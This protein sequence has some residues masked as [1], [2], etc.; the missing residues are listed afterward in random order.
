MLAEYVEVGED[1]SIKLDINSALQLAYIHSPSHQNQLETLYLS[2]LDVTAERFRLNTQYV[3]GLGAKYEQSSNS[4]RLTVGSSSPATPLDQVRRLFANA[5]E[6]LVGFANSFIFEFN[7][8]N[9]SFASSLANF[10][11]VQPL[12]RDSG[13]YIVLEQLTFVE[14]N[15]LANL[16]AY[17]QYRQ[18]FYT[19]VVIGELGVAG[20]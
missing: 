16:R 1:D 20:L 3:G 10:S 11:F 14:R 9:T 18:G 12:L 15:L 17:H 6:L 13:R 5:G 7:G 8:R 19:Q 2:A 4:N